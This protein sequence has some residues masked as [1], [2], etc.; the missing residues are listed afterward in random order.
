MIK[1]NKRGFENNTTQNVLTIL[2][3]LA[4]ITFVFAV[5]YVV[6]HMLHVRKLVNPNK[7]HLHALFIM[8]SGAT[9]DY[10]LR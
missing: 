5:F 7:I 4:E 6:L 9:L 8:Y 1:L 2:K 3:H 10:N